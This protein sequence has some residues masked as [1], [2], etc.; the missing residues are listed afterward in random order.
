MPSNLELKKSLQKAKND[1]CIKDAEIA[2]LQ[3]QLSKFL[4]LDTNVVSTSNAIDVVPE[5]SS[6]DSI[7]DT[8]HKVNEPKEIIAAK[9]VKKKSRSLRYLYLW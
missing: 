7:C 6:V 2:E 4:E 9:P 1:L 8:T 3:K 5:A